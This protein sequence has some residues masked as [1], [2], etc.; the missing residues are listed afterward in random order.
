[1]AVDWIDIAG[2][3]FWMGGGPRAEENPRHRVTL[4]A[5]RLARTP[6]TRA[7]YQAFLDATGNEVPPFWDEE[8][9]ADP[10]MPAVGPSW[11]DAVAYCAWLSFSASTE[12]GLPTEAEWESAA[13]AGRQVA[14]PWGDEGPEEVPDYD[15]RWL[16][17]PEPVEL[18]PSRHPWGLCG[19]GE[20][21]HEW[22][23]DWYDPA[24][25]EVSPT[26]DPRGPNEG[27]RRASRGGSW[28]HAIK[29]TRCAARSS[30]P[31]HM[32][33]ADYGFRV[34]SPL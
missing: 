20:N 28:R 5:Y 7:E 19:L 10:G 11:D 32:R 21:V 24:Y 2:G 23:A 29:V 9:F 26:I 3:T 15:R 6:V 13:L 22:C 34:R 18:Y 27:R 31:P 25:Y 1:M 17:G 33:Y 12:I 14:Y 8:R 4:G 16:E 30:I